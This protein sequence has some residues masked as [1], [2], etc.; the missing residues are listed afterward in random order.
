MRPHTTGLSF[1]LPSPPS[2]FPFTSFRRTH[3]QDFPLEGTDLVHIMHTHGCMSIRPTVGRWAS[4]S[5]SSRGKAFTAQGMTQL[6]AG[7]VITSTHY[8]PRVAQHVPAPPASLPHASRISQKQNTHAHTYRAAAAHGCSAP[9]RCSK[10]G[11]RDGTWRCGPKA[12]TGH[13]LLF[14]SL[15][16]AFSGQCLSRAA[17][18][19]LPPSKGH[20]AEDRS[21]ALSE[22]GGGKKRA[23]GDSHAAPRPPP[24]PCCR[25]SV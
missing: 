13:P 22:N 20:A 17:G 11:E 24:P 19:L 1:S 25:P 23:H 16:G 9:Q 15:A 4:L 7:P 2:P 6:D 5:Y 21:A 10:E 3:A 18:A 8:L 12:H 14:S